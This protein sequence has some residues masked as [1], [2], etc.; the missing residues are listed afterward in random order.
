M[1]NEETFE[2][3]AELRTDLG[4]GASRRL[5]RSGKVPAVIYGADKAPT[6]ITL[7][8]NEMFHHLEHEAFYSHI[9]TVNLPGS[10]EKVVL[11]DLQRHPAKPIIMH[12]DLLRISDSATL[13]MH[14]PLH[15]KGEDLAPGVK[16]GGGKFNHTM[17]EVEVQCLPKDLPEFIEVDVSAMELDQTIHL[18][19]LVLPAGVTL[20]TL[21]LGSD[22]D[23]PVVAIHRLRG[24][25]TVAPASEG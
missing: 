14:V 10:S 6:S 8:H 15:F 21:A 18:S 17:V 12:A 11:K 1:S 19:D 9:L 22:H 20:V 16:I 5:R 23:L 25:E 3:S 7:D 24:D 4:K 13:R 2:L